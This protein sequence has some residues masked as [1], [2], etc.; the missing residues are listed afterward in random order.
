MQRWNWLRENRGRRVRT[1]A[2]GEACHLPLTTCH[3]FVPG[4]LRPIRQTSTDLRPTVKRQYASSC[5]L[6]NVNFP[7]KKNARNFAGA[8][9]NKIT[10]GNGL[11]KKP[12]LSAA[13]GRNPI[14]S[15]VASLFPKI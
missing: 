6:R 2:R 13:W 12:A 10:I 3:C 1:Q 4:H 5:Y 15:S 9:N 11:R 8:R 14:K 7:A